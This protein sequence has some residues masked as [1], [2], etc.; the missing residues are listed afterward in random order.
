MFADL[1]TGV[2]VKIVGDQC[3]NT[4]H[5]SAGCRRCV[6]ACP[7][8][9]ITLGVRVPAIEAAACVRC[10]ACV[11]VCPT[12][13]VTAGDAPE[14]RLLDAC[15][16]I[17]GGAVT[18]ACVANPHPTAN[19]GGGATVLHGRC[20]AS[21]SVEQLIGLTREGTRRI[22]LDMSCCERCPIGSASAR[23]IAAVETVK[24]LIPVG[25]ATVGL[26]GL[27]GMGGVAPAKGTV[28]AFVDSKRPSISRRSL[29]SAMKIRAESAVQ[30]GRD[31]APL[32]FRRSSGPVMARLPQSIP[33]SRRRLLRRL[34]HLGP[35]DGI[36]VPAVR[37][38][39][40]DVL[41]AS[42]CSACGLCARY[43]PTGALSFVTTAS[44][45]GSADRFA[46]SFQIGACIDCGICA[47]ACPEKA[48]TFETTIDTARINHP[49]SIE[50][51][52][53]T[54]T[55]CS[56]CALVTAAT[57]GPE[58]ARCFS[59]RLGTGVVTAL[60]DDAGLMADLLSR[61]DPIG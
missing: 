1:L 41:I 5:E 28:A 25:E 57:D 55:T 12:D 3:L 45:A 20:L 4:R 50:L 49:L 7:T 30:R 8:A 52:E 39:F 36:A 43:C 37:V 51:Y 16:K 2:I 10:G 6:S 27:P 11:P 26:V 22:E 48:V 53:G 23:V 56:S 35:G 59:C 46:L 29:F 38:P 13:A 21:L 19:S 60:R 24:A 32:P 15:Q 17:V 54:L 33:G 47:V 40:A 61:S 44:P 18:V 31:I 34:H 42:S 14:R 9:A 58:P